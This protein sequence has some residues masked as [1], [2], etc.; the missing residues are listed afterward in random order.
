MKKIMGIPRRMF[1]TRT[2]TLLATV[3]NGQKQERYTERLY[4]T[5]RGEY[6][7]HG[8]GGILTKYNGGEDLRELSKS[9]LDYWKKKHGVQTC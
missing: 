2:S 1:N 6:F 7:I 8:W 3:K 5:Q 4:Y 9:A